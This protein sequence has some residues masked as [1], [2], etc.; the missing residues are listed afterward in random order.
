MENN[1]DAYIVTDSKGHNEKLLRLIDE[2][3]PEIKD[4]IIPQ[5]YYMEEYVRAE[6]YGYRN[7]IYTLYIT[8]NTEDEII[9]FIKHN[10]L[11]AL[12]MPVDMINKDFID[13]IKETDTFIYTHTIND[14]E[15]VK[16]YEEIGIDGFYTDDLF[17][18]EES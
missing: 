10:E 1:K 5:I 15:K 18:N 8:K 16:E 4:R 6:Y 7:I 11:F 2:R 13:R 12:T 9:D 3:H 14:L 17:K